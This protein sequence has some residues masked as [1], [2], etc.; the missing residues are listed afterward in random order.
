[1]LAVLL[2]DLAVWGHSSSWYVE[3]PR[4]TDEYFHQPEV[5]ETLNKFAPA[6]RSSF[7]I[8]TAPHQFDPALPP[9]PPLVSHSTDWVLWTQPDVY[10]MHGIHNAA[11]Y[12]AFGLERYSQLASRMRVWG[13]LTDPDATLRG[14]SREIDL[15]NVRFLISMRN[16]AN[17]NASTSGFLKADQKLGDGMF[18]GND[19]GLSS[20]LKP[21]A[22]TFSV[23]PVEV[24]HVGLITNIAWSERV[25]D[26]TTVARLRVHSAD[27][28]AWEFPLRAGTDTSEWSYDRPDISARI[29][30]RKA[31]VATSYTVNDAQ[32]SYDAHTYVTTISLPQT[33]NVVSGEIVLAPDARWPDLSM[34]VFRISLINQAE[35]QAYPL[36]RTMV[37]MD[38][39]IGARNAVSS[40]WKLLA[41]T[42][43][44]EIFENSRSL[45]RAWLAT[46]TKVLDGPA[47]LA[48]IRDGKFADGSK[49]DPGTTALIESPLAGTTPSGNGG[50]TQ[51]TRYEPNQIDL[52]T[53][54]EAP[55]VLVLSENHYP[56]WRA[57]VDGGFVETLRVDYNLRGVM[58]PAGAHHVTFVY[59][60]KSVL[61]GL[62]IS[63]FVFLV[64]ILGSQ[65]LV[66][67]R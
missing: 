37:S 32:G 59:R 36:A 42:P 24:D 51:I 2:L 49:W 45:P 28:R 3:S 25:P 62:A 9:I 31:P 52:L 50:T 19:F 39:E 64:M 40:R 47:M 33:I 55:S 20:L 44:V 27:G 8:L 10:M 13:E 26:N 5:V 11:G 63:L 58:L 56:G 38:D 29:R 16:Q 35:S 66:K 18:A 23:P 60:P 21:K 34:V 14:D 41:Q 17:V 15:A 22:L 6:D 43:Y 53:K 46:Q 54:S 61:I 57:Y 65:R 67:L 30:H 1:M 48:V 7:R 12:D 4:T